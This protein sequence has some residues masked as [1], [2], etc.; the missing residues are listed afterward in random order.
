MD[1]PG[2]RRFEE[3]RAAFR[4]KRQQ[5]AERLAETTHDVQAGLSRL[6]AD[7]PIR[8]RWFSEVW[9]EWRGACDETGSAGAVSLQEFLADREDFR[10]FV[11]NLSPI[12]FEDPETFARELTRLFDEAIRAV[13]A[14]DAA[15]RVLAK[16]APR[17]VAASRALP[18]EPRPV[19]WW[20]YLLWFFIRARRFAAWEAAKR[21]MAATAAPI[22]NG[23]S[24]TTME[25]TIAGALS[26]GMDDVATLT[27]EGIETV[28]AVIREPLARIVTAHHAAGCEVAN[29]AK[30]W[31]TGAG[32]TFRTHRVPPK[33]TPAKWWEHLFWSFIQAKRIAAWESVRDTMIWQDPQLPTVPAD[34]GRWQHLVA[35]RA[36]CLRE[37]EALRKSHAAVFAPAD[38]A[39]AE[40]ERLEKAARQAARLPEMPTIPGQAGF[41]A[42][43]ERGAQTLAEVR[44]TTRAIAAA[45][46]S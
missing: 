33:P 30:F 42:L 11:E 10:S 17:H 15:V 14:S 44:L 31:A 6:L 21:A 32:E 40:F 18:P 25:T 26:A 29:R 20:E 37:S 39:I 43:R 38:S 3:D 35:C 9:H 1:T 41:E 27:T 4:Q 12:G 36:E 46:N 7:T 28:Q 24:A 45:Y 13:P 19:R 2:T 34:R 22:P 23:V 8:G 5:C 16:R